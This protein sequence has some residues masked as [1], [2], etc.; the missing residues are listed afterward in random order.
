MKNKNKDKDKYKL[1]NRNKDLLN[2]STR[3]KDKEQ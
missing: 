2:K 3:K 1:K